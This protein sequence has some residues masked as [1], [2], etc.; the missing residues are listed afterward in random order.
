M[1]SRPALRRVRPHQVCLSIHKLLQ[2][3]GHVAALCGW[4]AAVLEGELVLGKCCLHPQLQQ[5]EPILGAALH[6][7]APADAAANDTCRKS[8][9]Q[10]MCE[11]QAHATY[12]PSCCVLFV[13]LQCPARQHTPMWKCCC[14]GLIKRSSRRRRRRLEPAHTKPATHANLR[15]EGCCCCL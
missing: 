2:A 9:T 5:A 15:L 10:R 3:A 7:M 14:V 1:D 11:E 8:S 6:S 12:A 4:H 13:L